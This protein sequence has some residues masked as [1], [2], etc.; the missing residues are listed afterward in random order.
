M[1]V[2]LYFLWIWSWSFISSSQSFL[3]SILQ[4][5]VCAS[6]PSLP[7]RRLKRKEDTAK[8]LIVDFGQFSKFSIW[9]CGKRVAFILGECLWTFYELPFR[10]FQGL[11]FT[12]EIWI[13]IAMKT[14]PLHSKHFFSVGED[15]CHIIIHFQ[16]NHQYV[17]DFLPFYSS[18]FNCL[19]RRASPLLSMNNY[20]LETKISRAR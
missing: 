11:V 12:R 4:F 9:V 1:D 19:P 17:K 13:Q 18:C 2:N 5:S 16:G 14:F 6:L 20:K 7:R 10:Q 15:V 3:L 8:V